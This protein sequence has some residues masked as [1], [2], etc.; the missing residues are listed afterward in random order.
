MDNFWDFDGLSIGFSL[1]MDD[2]NGFI[3]STYAKAYKSNECVCFFH[4]TTKKRITINNT[5]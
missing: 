1:F 3:L 4:L 5:I 2:V